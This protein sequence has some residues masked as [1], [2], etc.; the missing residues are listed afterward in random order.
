MFI[1]IDLLFSLYDFSRKLVLRQSMNSLTTALL[2]LQEHPA[3]SS[4]LTKA[5]KWLSGED[6]QMFIDILGRKWVG[7]KGYANIS[8]LAKKRTVRRSLILGLNSSTENSRS[9]CAR[10]LEDHTDDRLVLDAFCSKATSTDAT[11]SMKFDAMNALLKA[12]NE[13]SARTALKHLLIMQ[14]DL[15]LQSYLAPQL[16]ELRATDAKIDAALKRYEANCD[17]LYERE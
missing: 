17:C 5:E 10:I 11:S 4:L 3:N 6:S 2:C 12:Q 8:T 7:K 14:G 16:Q 1:F 13:P 15:T 9:V